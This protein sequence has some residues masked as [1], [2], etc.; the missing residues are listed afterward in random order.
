[1]ISYFQT[2]GVN[3]FLTEILVSGCCSG[4]DMQ[5]SQGVVPCMSNYVARNSGAVLDV[6]SMINSSK[7]YAF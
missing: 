2:E 1:M 4:H 7:R 5:G 6:Y 3:V